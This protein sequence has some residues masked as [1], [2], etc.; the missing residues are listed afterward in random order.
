[1][2]ILRIRR[3]WSRDDGTFGVLEDAE[4]NFPLAMTCEKKWQNNERGVSCIPVGEYDVTLEDSPRFGKKMWRVQC[5]FREGILFHSANLS[6]E[7]EGC[8][9]LGMQFGELNGKL[10]VLHSKIAQDFFERYLKG[11]EKFRLILEKI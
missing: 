1:M 3:F 7:L 4:K 6:S 5:S 2:K 9:A 10:A 8:I 11:E